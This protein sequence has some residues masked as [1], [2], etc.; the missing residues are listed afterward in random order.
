MRNCQITPSWR[1]ASWH[2]APRVCPGA[3]AATD[4]CSDASWKEANKQR[5]GCL[6]V[7]GTGGNQGCVKMEK[8]K[9]SRELGF[10]YKLLE[11]SC[12]QWGG[13]FYLTQKWK[14]SLGLSAGGTVGQVAGEPPLSTQPSGS[15]AGGAPGSRSA[16][17]LELYLQQAGTGLLPSS[18]KTPPRQKI[19]LGSSKELQSTHRACFLPGVEGSTPQQAGL[20]VGP[21]CRAAA[22]LSVFWSR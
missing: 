16:A 10:I 21:Q 14:R 2:L 22:A 3:G 13:C 19:R 15:R 17:R 7:S 8:H 20:V 11:D 1:P 6:K 5:K 4:A 18:S 9:A 12:K